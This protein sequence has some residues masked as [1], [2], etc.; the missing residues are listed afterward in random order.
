VAIDFSCV[1]PSPDDKKATEASIQLQKELL[2]QENKAALAKSELE[3]K[4]QRI[5]EL[6]SELSVAT[7]QAKVA[8]HLRG[9]L[10]LLGLSSEGQ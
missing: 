5:D 8:R 6:E 3:K 9:F 10:K 2:L 4:Q 1:P 7:E